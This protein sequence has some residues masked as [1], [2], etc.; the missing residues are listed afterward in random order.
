MQKIDIK[1]FSRKFIDAFDFLTKK[2]NFKISEHKEN[3]L[4]SDNS[5]I[6]K[7]IYTNSETKRII[8]F[9][10]IAED[11]KTHMFCRIADTY[12]K[13]INEH[14]EIPTYTDFANCL[15]ID[16]LNDLIEVKYNY[17]ETQEYPINYIDRVQFILYH[18]EN[19]FTKNYWPTI[20]EIED[21][22]QKNKGFVSVGKQNVP[23]ISLI[24]NELKELVNAGYEIVFDETQIP[25]YEQS[26]MGPSIKYYN[27]T[28]K[29]QIDITFQTRDQEF[30]VSTNRSKNYFYGIATK[31]DYLKLKNKILNE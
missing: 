28:R 7:I 24:K 11:Y 29:L 1:D 6:H 9:V 16:D 26:F 31:D 8:E 25:P 15:K 18:L 19:I 27:H 30:Y 22:Q 2:Y 12:V 14:D 3:S 10:F 5:F 23:Y 13:R 20:A 17:L 21:I 4:K